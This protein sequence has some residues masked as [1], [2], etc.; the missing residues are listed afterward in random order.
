MEKYPENEYVYIK[1]SSIHGLGLFTKKFIDKNTKICIYDGQEMSIRDFTSKYGPYKFNSL[2]T[3]RLKRINKIIVAKEEPYKTSNF[4]NYINE[5]SP[6]C[7]LK[8]R[9]LYTLDD[10]EPDTEL[11]L[12]YPRDYFR[13]W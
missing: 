7:I 5:G 13:D 12:T 3:Y 6:N 9:A 1:K 10:L 2:N 8:K 4:V 11:L